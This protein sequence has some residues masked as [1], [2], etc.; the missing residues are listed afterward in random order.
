MEAT[1]D[2]GTELVELGSDFGRLGGVE[3]V[4]VHLELLFVGGDELLGGDAV[5]GSGLHD[6]VELVALDAFGFDMY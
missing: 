1:G 3:L 2:D 4:A 5:L 6:G